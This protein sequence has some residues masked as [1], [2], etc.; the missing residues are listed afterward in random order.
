M[1]ES[2][3]MHLLTLD[4]EY[5]QKTIERFDNM[6][7][8]I[9]SWTVTTIGAVLV[10][11]VGAK[12]GAIAFV[13]VFLVFFFAFMEL[14]YMDMQVRVIWRSRQLDVL[15][16]ATSGDAVDAYK[17]GMSQVFHGRPFRFKELPPLLANR[18]EI[19]AFYGGLATVILLVGGFLLISY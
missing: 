11:S 15:I 16:N 4:L 1:D 7:F 5:V 12:N 2:R 9:K 18:P 8:A 3:L 14:V 13:G 19:Y 17:F 10:V 6:R